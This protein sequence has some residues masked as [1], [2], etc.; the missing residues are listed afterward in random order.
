MPKL[1]GRMSWSGFE[2]QYLLLC[3]CE[4]IMVLLFRLST[5]KNWRRYLCMTLYGENKVIKSTYLP[6]KL[7]V[8]FSIFLFIYN[9]KEKKKYNY[10]LLF[11]KESFRCIH[12]QGIWETIQR[13]GMVNQIMIWGGSK[14]WPRNPH[15]DFPIWE[16][17]KQ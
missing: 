6:T 2:S 17:D 1:L 11:R 15:I 4:F 7:N 5:K 14:V 13:G 3:V 16:C 12:L 9:A 10:K 8:W